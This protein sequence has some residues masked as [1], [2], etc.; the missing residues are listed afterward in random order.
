MGNSLF[1]KQQIIYD[2]ACYALSAIIVHSIS[3]QWYEK[4][5]PIQ[6]THNG[7]DFERAVKFLKIQSYIDMLGLSVYDHDSD[8]LPL[9]KKFTTAITISHSDLQ[10]FFKCPR[11]FYL[12]KKYHVKNGEQDNDK[13]TLSNANDHALK[14]EFHKC[15]QAKEV[16]PIMIREGVSAVPFDHNDVSVWQKSDYGKGGIKFYDTSRNLLLGGVID[17]VLQNQE[18]KLI[19]IDFKTTSKEILS[20][21][22]ESVA[23]YRRQIS[24]YSYLL[25]KKAF[26]MH[27]VGYLVLDK[28][29]VS[30]YSYEDILFG[31][32]PSN[33]YVFNPRSKS[34][35]YQR[36]LAFNT[37]VMEVPVD[38][39]WIE[40]TLDEMSKCL[41]SPELPPRVR[42]KCFNCTTY[43]TRKNYEDWLEKK[44]IKSQEQ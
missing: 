13:F 16:H 8:L 11:C 29:A 34:E 19:V 23:S 41:M 33:E 42:N 5:Y 36:K 17:E 38:Y 22:D 39:S 27:S 35:S 3:G 2:G 24:F 21:N 25:H 30:N 10:L 4:R 28:P 32:T 12:A 9:D 18:G 26:P 37:E 6:S 44:K 7:P 40:E 20:M 43:Y 1:V 15:R 31:K 14:D